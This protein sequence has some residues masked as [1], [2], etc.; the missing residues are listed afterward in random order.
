MAPDGQQQALTLRIVNDGSQPLH[1]A[2]AELRYWLGG[3]APRTVTGQQRAANA[4]WTSAG[5]E[6]SSTGPN[7][8]VTRPGR[9]QGY[10]FVALRFVALSPTMA[11]LAPYGG[12]ATMALRVQRA[13]WA[14]HGPDQD[15]SYT[16]SAV[17]VPA[18]HV[19]LAVDGRLVWGTSPLIATRFPR[20]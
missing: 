12:V 15:W 7:T 9:T 13:D 6:W 20:P 8:V 2:H 5:V 1:L 14:P 17:P 4:D 18:S 11:T 3:S 19:T 16:P 10:P